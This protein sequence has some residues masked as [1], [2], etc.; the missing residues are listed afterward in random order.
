[1]RSAKVITWYKAAEVLPEPEAE[2][3]VRTKD[4]RYHIGTYK[5]HLSPVWVD[6]DFSSIYLVEWWAP[7]PEPG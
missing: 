2:V 6:D 3:L 5:P 4:G 1:M 7:I